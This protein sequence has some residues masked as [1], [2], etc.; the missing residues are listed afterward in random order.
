MWGEVVNHKRSLT[1]RPSSQGWAPKCPVINIF[2]FV[3]LY[4][5]CVVCWFWV[6]ILSSLP[7][8]DYLSYVVCYAHVFSC[9]CIHM[10]NI[11]NSY[12]HS[13][14]PP[15]LRTCTYSTIIAHVKSHAHTFE[16]HYPITVESCNCHYHVCHLS[17][18]FTS[19]FMMSHSTTAL[20]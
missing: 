14:H 15:H 16:L 3:W 9:T 7:L 13:S 18:V 20:L 11:I 19:Y 17:V 12:P 8:Y 1:H 5:T 6:S 4:F 10:S 2:V